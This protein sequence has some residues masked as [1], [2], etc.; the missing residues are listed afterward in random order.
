VIVR[1]PRHPEHEPRGLWLV[2][3]VGAL[4]GSAMW[5][6]GIIVVAHVIRHW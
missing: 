1:D 2:G 3:V 6:V 4:I 5:A